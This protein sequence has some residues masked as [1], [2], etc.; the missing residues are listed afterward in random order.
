AR[1]SAMTTII[2]APLKG[3]GELRDQPPHGPV[4]LV[5]AQPPH[6]RERAKTPSP[7][8]TAGGTPCRLSRDQEVLPLNPLIDHRSRSYCHLRTSTEVRSP[9][10]PKTKGTPEPF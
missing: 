6:L 7:R 4:A 5:G 8:A 9:V 1:I 3:R 2:P 10:L